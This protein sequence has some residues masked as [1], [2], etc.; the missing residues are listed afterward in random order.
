MT[1][2][3]VTTID[4]KAPAEQVWAILD[5]VEAWPEWTSSMSRVV[6]RGTRPLAP[7]MSAVISQPRLGTVTWEVTEVVPGASFT[8]ESSWPGV[9]TVARHLVTPR[10]GG[11]EVRLEIEH[12]GA[13]AGVLGSLTGGLTGRYIETEAEGLKR[14]SELVHD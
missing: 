7:G 8:W 5:D 13:L 9:T 1:A 10:P 14:A 4:I 11:C 3:Q 6:L 12:R 2:P